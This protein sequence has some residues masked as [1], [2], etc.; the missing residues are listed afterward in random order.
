VVVVVGEFMRQL[1][2]DETLQRTC[3]VL[4]LDKCN[5]KTIPVEIAKFVSLRRLS[6]VGNQLEHLQ[7]VI[8]GP[9][10]LEELL[11]QDNPLTEIPYFIRNSVC[12]NAR[13]RSISIAL[14]L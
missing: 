5:L 14:L 10:E 8:G 12:S 11:I 3:T 6:L 7:H 2:S 13:Q 9:P 4:V 1:L